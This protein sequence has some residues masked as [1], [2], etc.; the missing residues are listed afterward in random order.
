MNV[1]GISA[2]YHES[3]CCLLQGGE[4]VAAAAEERFTRLKHD[5][6]VPENAFRYCLR[7]AGIGIRD[8]DALAFYELPTVKLGRQLWSGHP[9][10]IED[11]LPWLDHRRIERE[12]RGRLGYAGT[13]HE[14]GHHASHAAGAFFFSG[15]DDAAILTV[16]GVGEWAT[17]TYAHGHGAHLDILE[18]VHFPSSLGLLYSAVTAYLGFRVNSGEYKVMG[19]SPYGKPRFAEALRKVVHCDAEGGFSLDMRYFDF[20]EGSSMYSSSF[21]DLLGFPARAADAEGFDEN[22]KDLARSM[23]VVLEEILLA[24]VAYLHTRVPSKNLCL[25]GGV[26]L[27]SVANG[28]IV[29]EGPFKEVFIPSSPG[30]AGSA[31]GAAALATAKLTGERPR[32]G[33]VSHDYW[34]PAFASDEIA[35]LLSALPFEAIDYRQ[36]EPELLDAVVDRLEK[37]RV[38]GWFH[39]RMELGPRALGGRSILADPRNAEILVRLNELVKMREAFR[40][41]APSVLASQANELLSM[42]RPDPFMSTTWPV[43]EGAGMPAITHV[44]GSAR[45]QT[46]DGVE[47]RRY[48]ALIG[49]FFARTGCPAIVNTSFNVRGEPVVCS[50]ID[51]IHCFARSGIET[52][53]LEDFVIDR[54]SLPPAWVEAVAG[55]AVFELLERDSA[56][57]S[58][59]YT[60]I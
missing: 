42:N 32:Q 3:A 45:P 57:A 6:S 16:D 51:A 29:R 5:A 33:R 34:G 9:R 12:I 58:A 30:D 31:L 4:L 52:L 56:T 24:K 15:F 41:F 1:I 38:V 13:I 20:L 27:N 54:E 2:G 39:G 7:E 35:R 37:G 23:Q 46:V 59:L 48:A 43:R 19:L 50:P 53:V 21:A 40:P 36:R 14:F 10:S 47:N 17:T 26:A 18:E 25:A 28:R 11:G 49:R 22:H 8:V 60:F 55:D 44:D